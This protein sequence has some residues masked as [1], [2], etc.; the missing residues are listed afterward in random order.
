MPDTIV[1]IDPIFSSTTYQAMKNFTLLIILF[2]TR[3]ISLYADICTWDGTSGN[4]N[5]GSKWSCGQAPT[6]TDDVYINS[7]TV[8]FNG[9]QNVK[10]FSLSGLG[11]IE[12]TGTL[13]VTESMGWS[14]GT[15]F[16]SL[17]V[18]SGATAN[19]VPGPA[20][21]HNSGTVTNNGT[22]TWTDGYI[23]ASGITPGTWIN[24]GSFNIPA[25]G[26]MSGQ[27]FDNF[28]TL[29]KTGSQTM[30]V[31]A[32]L[33]VSFNNKAGGTVTISGGGYLELGQSG[34]HDGAFTIAAGLILATNASQTF[35]SGAFMSGAGTFSTFFNVNNLSIQTANWTV[36]T[37]S[38]GGGV[39]DIAP[40][41]S[42]PN[43]FFTGGTLTGV[44]IKTVTNLMTWSGGINL[45]SIAVALGATA[46][47][48][49]NTIV[50][51]AG[52]FTNN[53]AATWTDWYI[54]PFNATPGNWVNN[55]TFNIP[56]GGQMSGQ[57]FDN[58]GTLNKTSGSA[59]ITT[60]GLP[61]TFNN[62]SGSTVA[63]S[64]GGSLQLTLSGV[65]DG[66]FTIAADL[67]LITYASQAF[68]NGAS[69]SGEGIFASYGNLTIQTAN[70][71]IET[72]N[73]GSAV[74]D[75]NLNISFDTLNLYGNTTL[76]GAGT[77]TVTGHMFWGGSSTYL[78]HI[79]ISTSATANISPGNDIYHGGT[80]T[81]NGT[82]TWTDWY[83]Q[84]YN[85]TPGNW[86][87]NG[88][89]NIPAGGEMDGQNFNNYGTLNKTGNTTWFY[90]YGLSVAFSNKPS[91]I[92]N[93]VPDAGA[94]LIFNLPVSN[95][96]VLNIQ[97]GTLYATQAFDNTAA[98][99]IKGNGTFL[100]SGAPVTN[101]GRVAP[102][103]SPG[104]L[105]MT[106]F[107]NS[108]ATLDIEVAGT[109]GAGATDGHDHLV[110]NSN[111]T[112]G[113][114][115]E[116]SFLNGFAP[117][118]GS[119]VILT[120]TGTA[121]GALPS[122]TCV[123]GCYGSTL[124]LI[125]DAG[126]KTLTLRTF[127]ANAGSDAAICF[128]QN[129]TLTAGSAAPTA[130]FT[131]LW[132]TGA[133]TATINVSPSTTTTYSVVVT[134]VNG[135]T[136]D[137]SMTLTV[138]PLPVAVISPNGPTTFCQGNSVTLTASG[139]ISFLWNTSAITPSITVSTSNTYSV[140]VTDANGC[141]DDSGQPVTV[142][143]LPTA[144]ITPGGP[145]IFCSGDNVLLTASGGV[146]YAWSTSATTAAIT[147][148]TNGN[149][150]VV[151]TDANTCTDD[152]STFVTV[153]S[154]VNTWTGGGDAVNWSDAANWSDGIVPLACQGVSIPVGS[155]V[156]VP[157][158]FYAVGKT[159]DVAV[160]AQLQVA[161]TG[162]LF[163]EN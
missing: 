90:T 109:G 65:H 12:G 4:W 1:L 123:A 124:R 107:D 97:S 100:P 77:K 11:T 152:A 135:C 56:S 103:L 125:H 108:T 131:Y 138:H 31:S 73:F 82:T 120:Y 2:F 68:N 130:P 44:G 79:I 3:I 36:T 64:G 136:D 142:H 126:A 14:G 145:T 143:P 132:N 163:I 33:P 69:M 62:K 140:V 32:G 7:G 116:V 38:I 75:I 93:V 46:N 122:V 18:A 23:Y 148:L 95:E 84:P 39:A 153:G 85:S 86:V 88:T 37:T 156:T 111:V 25:G 27:N 80:F 119:F 71:T 40:N 155:S 21:V 8:T 129:A 115:L 20:F 117:P 5:D 47:I 112:L 54:E 99:I 110:V 42:F 61:V 160:T 13:T 43:L 45:S 151:A 29:N 48:S 60:G 87:N 53:G 106:P 22:I 96:N 83:I 157:A 58:Y 81:N 98:G 139:G 67:A 17:V 94:S 49:P 128:G 63:M 78:S 35:N 34:V 66:A 141:T 74:A 118:S 91:G 105:T 102:G 133:T 144:V 149:Y 121:S 72:T 15:N 52:T 104:I 162:T 158:G 92:I 50:Y 9:T 28:G 146:S 127:L 26:Q 134:D 55:G 70:W 101:T 10:V 76:T 147:A 114:S 137:D 16:V 51:N 57:N 161:L 154:I 24:N 6:A 30:I 150:T 59:N 89:F 159:L 41:L 113:G 19:V